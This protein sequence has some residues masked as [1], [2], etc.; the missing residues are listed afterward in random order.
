MASFKKVRSR[1]RTRLA[2]VAVAAAGVLAMTGAPPAAADDLG[3]TCP[4][5]HVCFYNALDYYGNYFQRYQDVT[6]TYQSV[7]ARNG[8]LTVVNTRNDDVAYVRYVFN[9]KTQVR[10]MPPSTTFTVTDGRATGIRI[11]TSSTC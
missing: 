5:P 8:F 6:S 2:S 1:W 3:S 4:Y 9:G 7:P 11:S 10:C